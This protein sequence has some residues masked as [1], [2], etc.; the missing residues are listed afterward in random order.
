MGVSHSLFSISQ[1]QSNSD[2]VDHIKSLNGFQTPDFGSEEKEARYPSLDEVYYSIQLADIKIIN[3]RI[4]IDKFKLEEG[5]NI[6]I[7]VFSIKDAESKHEGDLTITYPTGSGRNEWIESIS[8]I[9]TDLR[10][11]VR[12]TTQIC[13]I[14]GT[15]II[16]N[17]YEYYCIKAGDIYE[18][19]WEQI[20]SYLQKRYKL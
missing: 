9:K 1:I 8:G 18:N 20:Q 6:T 12:L 16:M 19:V 3:E 17:P 13:A 11:L 2:F 5:R 15:F 14:C 10:I 7:H 4:E